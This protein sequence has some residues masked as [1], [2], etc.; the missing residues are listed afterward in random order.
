MFLVIS[1]IEAKDVPLSKHQWL[2]NETSMNHQWNDDE[3]PIRNTGRTFP[4]KSRYSAGFAA[5]R[6]LARVF[7]WLNTPNP[8]PIPGVP[9][10]FSEK[11]T[12]KIVEFLKNC[13]KE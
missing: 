12:K 9:V 10:C 11:P 13:L 1:L 4:A 8:N 2:I 5:K 6:P 3:S 7:F